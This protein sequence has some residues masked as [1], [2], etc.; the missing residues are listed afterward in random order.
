MRGLHPQC[1][2]ILQH[3][4]H[5]T[6]KKRYFSTLIQCMD[7]KLS[8]EG[9]G[10]TQDEGNPPTKSL[11]TSIVWSLEKSKIFCLHFHKAQGPQTQQDGDQ[12][13]KTSLNMSC[14]NYLVGSVH[15]FHFQLKLSPKNR[16]ISNDYDNTEKCVACITEFLKLTYYFL[17]DCL[18]G[19]KHPDRRTGSVFI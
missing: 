10:V 11:D 14:A 7:P 13:E 5:L 12:N 18:Y 4:G 1:H 2:V 15:L 8:R 6:N 16:Q 3:R 17:A 9:G 19:T